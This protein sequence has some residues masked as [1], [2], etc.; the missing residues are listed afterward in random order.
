MTEL[1]DGTMTEY[2]SV[3]DPI[4]LCTTPTSVISV[5][6][7]FEAIGRIMGTCDQQK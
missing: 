3:T 1:Y 5:Q 6:F 4:P 7:D 2:S